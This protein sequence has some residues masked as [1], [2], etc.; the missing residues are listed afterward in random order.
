MFYTVQTICKEYISKNMQKIAIL[1]NVGHFLR[2]T[3]RS[4]CLFFHLELFSIP[5]MPHTE[6]IVFFSGTEVLFYILFL[7]RQNTFFEI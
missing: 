2:L 1:A 5:K 3:G 4:N 7:T 6:K